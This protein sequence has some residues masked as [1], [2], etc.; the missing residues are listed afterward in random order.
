MIINF[1]KPCTLYLAVLSLVGCMN[2]TTPDGLSTDEQDSSS[3]ANASIAGCESTVTNNYANY[4]SGDWQTNN[5]QVQTLL[6]AS[7]PQPFRVYTNHS[8]YSDQVNES[9]WRQEIGRQNSTIAQQIAIERNRYP[10]Q[11]YVP[12]F[13][14]GDMT[15]YGHGDQRTAMQNLMPQFKSERPGP[16]MFPGLGNHDYDQNVNDC[17]NNG[18]AR[19]A[20]CDHI[21][22]VKTIQDKSRNFNFDYSWR[23]SD[24][25][26][27]GS[28]AYS[29]DYGKLHVVQLNN[30]PTYAVNF[31]TGSDS[32]PFIG[33]KRHFNI[34]PSLDWLAQDLRA[35]KARGQLSIVNFHRIDGWANSSQLEGRFKDIVEQNRV[36]AIF[37]G[38]LHSRLGLRR[39]VGPV[40]VFQTGAIL[41][42]S[43][44][45]ME[46]D[47]PKRQAFVHGR[48]ATGQSTEYRY[49]IDTLLEYVPPTP[50]PV[51]VTLFR[52]ANYEDRVCQ[53]SLLPGEKV[54]IV[55]GH[56]CSRMAQRDKGSMKVTGFQ[57][58]SLGH[59]LFIYSNATLGYSVFDGLYDGNFNV[60]NLTATAEGVLPP[61]LKRRPLIMLG[62]GLKSISLSA[63]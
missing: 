39:H 61:P 5:A 44:L 22:W 21:A 38:H 55:A 12:L 4:I 48:V 56:A 16:L 26:H 14:N 53:F 35:A 6:F 20:V 11:H 7:D 28:L 8:P 27:Q 47:W 1:V 43:F 59:Q 33:P 9:R 49:D 54:E 23:S 31:S 30:E 3:S 15:D 52:L 29:F 60:P 10:N 34:T 36:I 58:A 41:N 40:P 17:S 32:N 18:C 24:K 2:S 50:G 13:V 63:W 19:D 45:K 37:V 51:Q 62:S 46:V 42:E 25:T 57:G